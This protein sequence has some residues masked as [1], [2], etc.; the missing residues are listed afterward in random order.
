MP[1]TTKDLEDLLED[2]VESICRVF[3]NFM[4]NSSIRSFLDNE[5]KYLIIVKGRSAVLR[6]ENGVEGIGMDSRLDTIFDWKENSDLDVGQKR[7]YC[8][9]QGCLLFK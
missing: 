5:F 8:D 2:K 9:K 7:A 6:P 1:K 3:P 4:S